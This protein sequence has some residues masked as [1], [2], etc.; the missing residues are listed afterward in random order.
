MGGFWFMATAQRLAGA[1]H[2]G[3]MFVVMVNTSDISK[4]SIL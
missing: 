1:L 2:E 3:Q 4:L